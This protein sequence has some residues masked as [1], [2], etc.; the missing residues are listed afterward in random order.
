MRFRFRLN[1][2]PSRD[3]IFLAS[4][5]ALEVFR[6]IVNAM[7]DG[8]LV[9]NRE[10]SITLA[11]PALG[12]ILG[13]AR[14]EMEGKGWA[15]LFFGRPENDRF[16]DVVVDVIQ[17]QVCHYNQQVTYHPPQGRPRELIV[18]TN[19]LTNSETEV[20]SVRGVL[21]VFKDISELSDL[22][23]QREELLERTRLLYQ[24]KLE[25]LD[26]LARAVAHEIRNPV[27]SIGGLTQRLL[28]RCAP[29]N[30]D[31]RYYQRI[32][33]GSRRLETVVA[34]VRDYADLPAPHPVALDLAPWLETI[35]E[36]YAP[37]CAALGVA[38]IRPAGWSA[39]QAPP[40]VW[41][42]CDPKLLARALRVIIDNALEAMPQGGRLTL[43]LG[44]SD[45]PPWAWLRV[46]DSGRGIRPD[47][48]PFIFD[49]FFST[50]ANGVGMNLA[51]A[52]R[53]LDEQEGKL[54]V[55]SQPGHGASFS[56]LLPPAPAPGQ[57]D[58]RL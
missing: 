55:E 32:L 54:T 52:K 13:L 9:I 31:C 58:A 26:R 18:T 53:V 42:R 40:P 14:E 29:D 56:L 50:K 5:A 4:K 48:L 51:I 30:P 10:G 46:A 49:P 39:G 24:E 20:H 27:M 6:N 22:H 28:S 17:N 41:T 35:G 3:G 21:V 19:L 11:N 2:H 12:G 36:E 7:S 38:L 47:D 8:V 57:A 23:R 15:E 1:R 33:E 16:N 44:R 45:D 34:Q 43:D 37:R 25:G